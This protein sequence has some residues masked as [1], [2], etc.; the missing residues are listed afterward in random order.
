[1]YRTARLLILTLVLLC[2]AP[3]AYGEDVPALVEGVKAAVRKKAPCWKL[4]H[5]QGRR[6]TDRAEAWVNWACGKDGVAAYLY[7]EPSVEAA[8]KLFQEMRT[9][10]VAAPGRAVD[11]Y[12]FGDESFVSS[13]N[14]YSR[15]SYVFFRK[16]NIIVRID[17]GTNGKA[18]SARTLKNAVRFARLFVEQLSA[19]PNNGMHPTPHHVASHQP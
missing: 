16:G 8:I 3:S 7:H 18:S 5:Q 1:M 15:S 13:F 11:S 12:K 4:F 14:P 17:S 6:E 9:A 19:P 2:C 10:P